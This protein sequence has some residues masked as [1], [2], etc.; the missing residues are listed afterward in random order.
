MDLKL[1][2]WAGLNLIIKSRFK[3]FNNS[4]LFITNDKKAIFAF[5]SKPNKKK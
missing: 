2:F 4:I 1:D 5:S 3:Q